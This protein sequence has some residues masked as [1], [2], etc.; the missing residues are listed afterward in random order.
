MF[1]IKPL[2]FF[3]LLLILLF[4]AKCLKKIEVLI[5]RILDSLLD[6][7]LDTLIAI[8]VLVISPYFIANIKYPIFYNLGF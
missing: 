3:T 1:L 6:F 2:G 5:K 8:I 7:R 4:V